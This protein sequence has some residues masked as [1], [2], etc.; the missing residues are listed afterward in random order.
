MNQDE[1]MK[2][3][4]EIHSDLPREGPGDTACTEQ[5]FSMLRDL[6]AEPRILDVGCGPG[7]QTLDLARLS[8]GTITA[9]DFHAH[10]LEEVGKRAADQGFSDR[11]EAVHG[12]MN[13]LKLEEEFFD[14]IWSEGAIY[15]MGFENGL[16]KWGRFLKPGGYL[17]VTEATWLKK[18]V[19]GEL[20]AFWDEGYPAMMDVEGNLSAIREAGY[21]DVGH[22]TLPDTAWWTH[23]YDPIEAKLPALEAKYLGDAE[24]SSLLEAERFEIELFRK[25]ADCYGYVFYVMQAR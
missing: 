8:G 5:A 24:A 18:D 2:I 14:L 13:D 7:M 9:V 19:T 6:P 25:Y 10:Y 17:A 12:D 4:F 1:M 22:F 15:I 23:Y 16:S 3:F 21:A 20:K 11:I